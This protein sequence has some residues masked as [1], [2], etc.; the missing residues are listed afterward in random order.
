MDLQKEVLKKLECEKSLAQRQLNT[1]LDPMARLPLEISSEIFLQCLP[2]FPEYGSVQVPML[3]LNVCNSWTDIA[4]STPALWA[5]IYIVLP[6]AEAFKKVLSIWLQRAGNRPLSIVIRGPGAFDQGVL[7]LIWQHG[8]QL[9]H[10][11]ICYDNGE[12]E[13]SDEDTE[14][15]DKIE[16]FG[17]IS[18]GSLPLLETLTIR[19]LTNLKDGQGYSE[20]EFLELLRLAPNLV[21]CSFPGII[22]AQTASTR[23]SMKYW[24]FRPCVGWCSESTGCIPAVTPAY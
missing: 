8:Q 19:G 5:N 18:P 13:N 6:C 12:D 7:R 21:E 17:G 9:K 14:Y 15:E 4:L 10:L 20:L 23:N 2:P 24:S 3:F 22:S 11:E 16:F 1:V